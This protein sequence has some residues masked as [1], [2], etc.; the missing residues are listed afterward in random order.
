MDKEPCGLRGRE[1]QKNDILSVLLDIII[2][3]GGLEGEEM[4]KKYQIGFKRMAC[5]LLSKYQNSPS[6]VAMELS[7]P[8]KTYEKWVSIYRKNP[9]AFNEVEVNFEEE[10]KNLRRELR[11]REET[12]AM[13][14]KAYAFLTVKN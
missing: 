7:I 5:E 11:E 10:N 9:Y 1:T 12:I 13:L 8:I 4:N 2:I 6:R 14:K 3:S